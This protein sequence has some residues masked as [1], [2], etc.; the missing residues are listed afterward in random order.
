MGASTGAGFPS[1]SAWRAILLV[2]GL[3]LLAYLPSLFGAF[4]YDD[5]RFAAQ[6]EAVHT[7][8]PRTAV[9]YFTDPTTVDPDAWKGIYRPLR[10]LEFAI[11][12]AISGGRPWWFHLRSMIWH[13]LAAV[14]V[15]GLFRR[16]SGAPS[17]PVPAAAWCGALLYALHPVHTECVAWIS[18]RG[19]LLCAVLFL[20]ALIS[21]LDGHRIRAAVLLVV[22]VFA[23][24]VAVVFVGAAL[25]VDLYRR[26]KLRFGWYGVY[27]AIGVGF[28]ALWFFL[29]A[30][31]EAGEMGQVSAW[32][33]GSYLMNLATMAKGFLYYVSLLVLPVNQAVAY[34]LPARATLDTGTV[35]SIV[36]LL[37]IA[38]AALVASRRTRFALGWF[39]VTI[40]P[41][42][43]LV[44]RLVIPT[45]ER[46]LLL[47]SIGFCFA[48]GWLLARTR[49]GAIVFLCCFALTF[50]RTFD[51]RTED[52][53]W[54][55][56]LAVTES[57]KG[58]HY[59][60]NLETERMERTR[61]RADAE[62]VVATTDAFFSCYMRNIQ[63]AP[64]GTPGAMLVSATDA[65]PLLV[66]KAK[67]LLL[68]GRYQE[69]LDAAMFA[70]GFGGMEEGKRL[71]EIAR[72]HLR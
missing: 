60:S 59:R 16:L 68:L 13:A 50:S 62:Q 19:D 72:E 64:A 57:P 3:A 4:V 63:L 48:A 47:P 44:I 69:A 29:V 2:A 40:L 15:L 6:N 1:L 23:K 10:T 61:A 30:G 43:N 7:L 41:V 28:T 14:L 25:L 22:A 38:V 52:T 42:S 51:W 18:S 58:L 26:D 39:L 21:H 20:A 67:A 71:A 31:G 46:F 66:N 32:W 37:L 27:A 11:D 12:W 9:S 24:E 5:V 70:A 55:S 53:V 8:S 49:I 33:G 65:G 35:V 54:Q 17:G 36:A 45:E 34:H 56:S